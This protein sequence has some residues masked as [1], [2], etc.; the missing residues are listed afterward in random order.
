MIIANAIEG[1]KLN[2]RAGGKVIVGRGLKPA[3]PLEWLQL[4]FVFDFVNARHKLQGD[5]TNGQEEVSKSPFQRENSYDDNSA[6]NNT[7]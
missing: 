3:I 4:G 6:S 5:N 2:K 1:K 7:S